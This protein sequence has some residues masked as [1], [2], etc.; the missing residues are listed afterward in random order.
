MT[1]SRTRISRQFFILSQ[2]RITT[3][4]GLHTCYIQR[5]Y[6]VGYWSAL[7]ICLFITDI[8]INEVLNMHIPWWQAH[9]DYAYTHHVP[10]TKFRHCSPYRALD[11][12][13]FCYSQSEQIC[14]WGIKYAHSVTTDNVVST[15][16]HH[17]PHT[18]IHHCS[19]YR[20]LDICFFFFFF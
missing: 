13:F 9:V 2:A 10:H 7:E 15:C 1:L 11:I 14:K 16:A 19:P 5:T 18:K 4:L 17:Y 12:C 3:V 20:T 8:Q 6:S